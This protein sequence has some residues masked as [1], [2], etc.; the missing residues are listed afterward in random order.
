VLAALLVFPATAGAVTTLLP[1]VTYQRQQQLIS[2]RPV[3]L[4]VVR[5]PPHGGLYQ[6]RPVL[7][8]GTVK[9]RATVPAMQRSLSRQATT[10]G[11]NGDLFDWASGSPTGV[12]LRN[13][14]L[15]TPPAVQRSGL[16]IA[17][18]G[19]L[20]VDRFRF[21]G[22]WT[23]GANPAHPLRTINRLVSK[24]GVGIYTRNY[25]G[26]TPWVRGSVE[27]VLSGFPPA[28]L[29]GNLTGTVTAVRRHGNTS[30]PRRGAVLK[31]R[32]FWR[33]RIL[34]EAPL[35]T[36]VTVR[37]GLAGV[38]SDAADAIGG[39]PLLVRNGNAVRQPDE[40]FSLAHLVQRHPRSAIGQLANGRL[41]FVVADGRSSVSSGLTMWD[42][43]RTM[44]RLGAVTAMSVDGGGSS[45]L[46]F[47][48]RVLNRPS[49]GA[50]RAV[51]E[52]LF[53]FYH[54]I[55]AP[56][57]SRALITPNGDA[58]SE[59]ATL[60]AKVVRPSV[61]DLKLL[62][63]NGTVAWRAR[64]GSLPGTF[65]KIVGSSVMADGVWRWVVEATENASGRVSTMT[66]SFKV[67]RTLGHLRL[68]RERLT[69]VPRGTAR[70]FV[71]AVLKRQATVGVSVLTRSG[72]VRKVLYQGT[73]GRGKH[74]WSWD[75]RRTA[76]V[77]V[78]GGTYIIRIRATNS[79]G[80]LTLADTI[81]VV[82]G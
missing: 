73:R 60:S 80:T 75:G 81:R 30:I 58:V 78:P 13:G 45:T 33:G 34:A 49:D 62:R 3:V 69:V 14:V 74:V 21:L 35:G 52:G 39:G 9:G 44:Q 46:G 25:G 42:L 4:H 66:R 27:V 72:Q 63:P 77:L 8:H 56:R 70:V 68:S 15:S 76:G 16:A 41:I 54:G 6:L 32:G 18:D 40:Y 67:N 28:L 2:G 1:G 26:R 64:R 53:L 71:S 7:S 43:A 51:A 20:I 47:D 37:L 5:T 50:P 17:F 31:A 65:R 48:G 57:A 38:P 29:N 79:F 23:P 59:R 11:I 10:V 12:F 19:S 55:Y 36:Q 82:H 22:S 24:P 61:I